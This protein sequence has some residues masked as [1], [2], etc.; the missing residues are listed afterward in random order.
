MSKRRDETIRTETMSQSARLS[1]CLKASPGRRR[2][3]AVRV[4]FAIFIAAALCFFV[5][6]LG[7]GSALPAEA[8][9]DSANVADVA[10]TITTLSTG[11]FSFSLSATLPDKPDAVFDALTGDI[12]A[13]WDH[14][15]SEAPERL[16]IEARPGGAFWEIFDATGAGVRH[17]VVTY[18]KRGE[19]LRFEGPL[20]LAGHAILLVTTYDLEAVST[21]STRLTVTVHG[22][23]E[24]NEGWPE[25]VQ[26]TWHHF[27]VERF[28]PY[29]ES[30]QHR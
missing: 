23:G 6:G 27:I 11:A 12:S 16:Y 10:S 30:G 26:K 15:V 4:R 2:S 13:W 29:V 18:A 9:G 28:V 17:A 20:G 21:E 3:R 14:S 24:M 7:T 19:R 25:I 5:N 1:K 22:S 8:D